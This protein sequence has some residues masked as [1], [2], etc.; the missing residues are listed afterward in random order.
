LERNRG[1][2]LNELFSRA[3]FTTE[4]GNDAGNDAVP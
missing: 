4:D 1:V 3:D 2:F